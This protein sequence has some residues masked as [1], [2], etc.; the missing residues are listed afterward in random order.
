MVPSASLPVTGPVPVLSL[1]ALVTRG[2]STLTG[3][4]LTAACV[5]VRRIVAEGDGV[6][7]GDG[8]TGWQGGRKN[9]PPTP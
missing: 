5:V 1:A 2:F 4:R 3:V 7:E 8:V 9:E 6:N